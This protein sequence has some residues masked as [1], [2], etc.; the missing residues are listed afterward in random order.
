M[1]AVDASIRVVL[2]L[3]LHII[4]SYLPLWILSKRVTT[5]IKANEQ[6]VV[7]CF[8]SRELPH[9]TLTFSAPKSH[10]LCVNS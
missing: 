5:K 1:K 10:M 7:V 2:H 4:G 6:R 8:D 9:K 3:V